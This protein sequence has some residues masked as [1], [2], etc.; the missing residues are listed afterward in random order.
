M[1][2]GTR[3]LTNVS[4][5]QTGLV[6]IPNADAISFVTLSFPFKFLAV[7]SGGFEKRVGVFQNGITAMAYFKQRLSASK[8]ESEILVFDNSFLF[9]LLEGA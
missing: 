4:D 9:L 8:N 3:A 2:T 5:I 1:I 7:Q 6:C